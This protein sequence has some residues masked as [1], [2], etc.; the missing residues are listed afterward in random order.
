MVLIIIIRFPPRSPAISTATSG[1]SD[2]AHI[3]TGRPSLV[4]I[5]R[6]TTNKNINKNR[7]KH[8]YESL[9]AQVD[10]TGGWWNRTGGK[11]V[12]VILI[13]V[14]RI[15]TGGDDGVVDPPLATFSG[16]ST[17]FS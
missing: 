3:I 7:E 1:C 11:G 9:S 16:F 12:A 14:V 8:Y 10:R 4:F 6:Q 2:A 17:P 5:A 13:S 15:H